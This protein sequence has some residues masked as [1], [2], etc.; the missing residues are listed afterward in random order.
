MEDPSLS[1]S[2][3]SSLNTSEC[4]SESDRNSSRSLR[5][6]SDKTDVRSDLVS[7]ISTKPSSG[8]EEEEDPYDISIVTSCT[9]EEETANKPRK[10]SRTRSTLRRITSF[11]R[12]DKSRN[13]SLVPS[14]GPDS[15]KYS[16][17]HFSDPASSVN[18]VGFRG[19][20]SLRNY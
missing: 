19:I 6:T 20:W 2:A 12:K 18:I 11:M 10:H 9:C 7:E 1:P 13:L 14:G 16:S 3:S 8:R 5:R 4:N 15:I 17:E